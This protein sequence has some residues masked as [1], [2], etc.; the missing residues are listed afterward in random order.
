MNTN[1]YNKFI[2]CVFYI[3]SIYTYVDIYEI[4]IRKISCYILYIHTH[5]LHFI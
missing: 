3:Y 4:Y 2:I 5:I 1:I